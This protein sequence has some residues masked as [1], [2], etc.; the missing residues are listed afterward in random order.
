[1]TRARTSNAPPGANG[2]MTSTGLLGNAC[3]AATPGTKSRAPRPT[4]CSTAAELR[5][6]RTR[7]R[8]ARWMR[9]ADRDE[10]TS[11]TSWA[12]RRRVHPAGRMA[13]PR[14]SAGLRV[15]EGGSQNRLSPLAPPSIRGI[16]GAERA[17]S[18]TADLSVRLDLFG[19][20]RLRVDDV[21]IRLGS[22]KALGVAIVLAIDGPQARERLRALLWPHA[23]E[24][25][26]C[27]TSGATCSG[28][29]RPACRCARTRPA[30]WRWASAPASPTRAAAA[31]R[32]KGWRA[33]REAS[34]SP[35]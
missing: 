5:V 7:S 13:S 14:S 18:M 35:G 20:A 6:T 29:A 16:G 33:W 10:L 22:R 32:C 11:R 25:A 2:T 19:T 17:P 1:M 21:P 9:A 27:A 23:A 15:D 12:E 8:T 24:A 4:T 26:R 31:R 34:S 28:C 30:S 3:A